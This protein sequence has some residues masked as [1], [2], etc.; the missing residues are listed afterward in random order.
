[1]YTTW[2]R[3]FHNTY[4]QLTPTVKEHP[5]YRLLANSSNIHHHM[6]INANSILTLVI[7]RI[8]SC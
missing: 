5:Y 7:P 1:M 6:L 2:W 8:I 4:Y 3:R